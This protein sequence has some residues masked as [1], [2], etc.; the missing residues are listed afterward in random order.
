MVEMIEVLDPVSAEPTGEQKAKADVH[1]DGD[2]HRSVH[3]WLITA[4]GRILLQRR[5]LRKENHP[6]L[7]DVSAAGHVTAGESVSDTAIRETFEELGIEL[8]AGELNPVGVTRESHVLNHG[9]YIDNEV[10]EVF[11]VRR[12]AIDISS[13][14]LQPSEVDDAR[15]VTPAELRELI[16]RGEAVDHPHEYDLLLALL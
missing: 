15:L 9:T 16:A 3:V 8:N 5:S 12:D 2:W 11:I 13:L 10:H 14:V 6:G 7:W 1:R 4:D